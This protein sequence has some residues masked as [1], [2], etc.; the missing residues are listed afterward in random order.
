M[1]YPND[2]T[3]MMEQIQCLLEQFNVSSKI[4]SALMID[5]DD[6]F[7]AFSEIQPWLRLLRETFDS[8]TQVFLITHHSEAIDYF[9]ADGAT[10]FERTVGGPTRLRVVDVGAKRH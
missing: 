8:G 4:Q 6:N 3:K 10:L 7:V 1:D 9:A 2:Q 5:E